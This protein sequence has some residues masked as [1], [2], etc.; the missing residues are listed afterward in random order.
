MCALDE[1][2]GRL[3]TAELQFRLASAVQLAVIG[4]RQP[5]DLPVEWT[6]GQHRVTYEEI[7]LR[8]DQAEYASFFL[9]R[10]ATYLMAVAMKDAIRAAVPNPKNAS[11][12][13]VRAAY[14]IARTIRNAFA[15]APFSPTWSID[16]D[17][18]NTTFSV[19]NLIR[20]DTTG[21]NGLPFD[22]RHYGGPLALFRLCRFVRITILKDEP[23]P[24]E[25]VPTPDRMIY[26]Q[27]DLILER[28]DALPPDTV[29]IGTGKSLEDG[30]DLGNRH[31][32]HSGK[33]VKP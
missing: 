2:V 19:G 15:H 16:D 22:W 13:D 31:V 9:H 24:R 25:T 20:L 1:H 4:E 7:A 21:L 10:S 23:K 27:G 5:L 29:P 12:A 3:F 30:L 11:D 28:V 33:D 26:Q 6:H 17:C 14:Q 8:Q 18:Q 32:P